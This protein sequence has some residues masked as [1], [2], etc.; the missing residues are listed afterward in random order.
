MSDPVAG[1]AGERVTH[2]HGD[3]L[4]ASLEIGRAHV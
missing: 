4:L 3:R 1:T 2:E